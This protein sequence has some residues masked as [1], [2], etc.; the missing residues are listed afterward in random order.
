[1][2]DH[3]RETRRV[4]FILGEDRA[5]SRAAETLLR[6]VALSLSPTSDHDWFEHEF[7]LV[8]PFHPQTGFR[9]WKLTESMGLAR[10]ARLPVYGGFQGGAEPEAQMFRA[11]LLFVQKSLGAHEA[12]VL[13]VRDSD[14]RREGRRKGM[15]Q[16]IESA[17]WPFRVVGGVCHREVEAWF[18][19]ALSAPATTIST[20]KRNLGFDPTQSPEK[21][22]SSSGDARDTKAVLVLFQ[23]S[24]EDLDDMLRNIAEQ[25][26]RR[27]GRDTGIC[28][29][30]D[31]LAALFPS[32]ARR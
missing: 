31:D 27:R 21:C 4:V 17:T 32:K 7:L 20:I 19:A 11:A 26:L 12:T 6:R 22:N 13:I 30:L 15:Q 8:S 24:D 23:L 9:A 25:E 14:N 10:D 18:L 2:S 28:E 1:M 16:A 29:F 3:I 5:H